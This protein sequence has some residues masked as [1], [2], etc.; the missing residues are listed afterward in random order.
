MPNDE[1]RA[2]LLRLARG[3]VAA[4]V[5][6][7]DVPDSPPPEDWT[8]LWAEGG[9]FVTLKTGGRLRGCLGCFRHPPPLYKTVAEYAALSATEDP[10]FS[11]RRLGVRDLPAVRIDISVLSPLAPC[12][13]PLALTLGVDGIY[14]AGD[15]RS[16]CFLPQVAVETGWDVAEFWERCCVDKAGLPSG[17][18]RGDGVRRWTFT[19]E[20]FGDG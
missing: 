12:A 4:A 17:A 19:A 18:W 1:Q 15:G 6:G 9:V 20:V 5:D 7:G 16:G 14:L 2:F 10:R 3:A 8:P 11:G 13:D